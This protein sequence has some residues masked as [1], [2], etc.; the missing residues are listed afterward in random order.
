MLL[1]I[2]F[3][4]VKLDDCTET[5]PCN[6]ICKTIAISNFLKY[7]GHL[8]FCFLF[9]FFPFFSNFFMVWLSASV[10]PGKLN[11]CHMFIRNRK[12]VFW[13]LFSY[14][15]ISTWSY[16]TDRSGV[17]TDHTDVSDIAIFHWKRKISHL[18]K[19]KSGWNLEENLLP[20]FIHSIPLFF[21]CL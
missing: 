8:P 5:V 20:I 6:S 17:A 11:T 19:L 2:K 3:F 7:A 4:K 10:E 21:V 15:H 18:L 1:L 12:I 9:L 13:F 14:F 16:L